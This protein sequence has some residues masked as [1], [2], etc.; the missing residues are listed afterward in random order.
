MTT[1]N[2]IKN[3]GALAQVAY[4]AYAKQAAEL[5]TE[6]RFNPAPAW[7]QLD[8]GTQVCWMAVVHQLWAEFHTRPVDARQLLQ[9][10]PQSLVVTQAAPL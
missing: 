7:D 4:E 1:D 2:T 6:G 10:D 8:E 5:D 3:W 9:P